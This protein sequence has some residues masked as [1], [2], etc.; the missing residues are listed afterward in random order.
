[1]STLSVTNTFSSG[2]IADASQVNTNFT[3]ITTYI[4]NR[5]AGSA[6]WDALSVASASVVPLIV[7]NST[8]SQNIA[9]FQANGSNATVIDSVGKLGVGTA[10]SA[11]LHVSASTGAGEAARL[12]SSSSNGAYISLYSA[13]TIKWTFGHDLGQSSGNF[14]FRDEVNSLNKFIVS[15]AT[16]GEAVILNSGSANGAY[17]TLQSAGATKWTFGHS[18]GQVSGAFVLRDEVNSKNR[19]IVTTAGSI[20]L[21]DAA[22]ATTATDGFVYVGTC[23]GAPSGAATAQTGRVALVYDTTNQKL[24]VY[25]GA[26]RGVTV[27]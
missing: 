2:T 5:N 24:M 17:I 14:V 23:A 19:V 25:N 1:M 27:S 9:N 21:T 18:L 12:N 16:G 7:N 3:D 22:V 15:A 20:L 11:W 10:P 26:W 13:G 4:N 8:G 6:T